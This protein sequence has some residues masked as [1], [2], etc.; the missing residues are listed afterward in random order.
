MALSSPTKKPRGVLVQQQTSCYQ[1]YVLLLLGLGLGSLLVFIYYTD[2]IQHA[3]LPRLKAQVKRTVCSMMT[4]PC[5]SLE[6]EARDQ[7]RERA[8]ERNRDVLFVAT[9]SGRRRKSF[10]VGDADEKMYG[11]DLSARDT[12]R[13]H[14]RDA[15]RKTLNVP[16][17]GRRRRLPILLQGKKRPGVEK[18]SPFRLLRVKIRDKG[19]NFPGS[20]GA[21]NSPKRRP[22][23]SDFAEVA[24]GGHFQMNKQRRSE[25]DDIPDFARN[26]RLKYRTHD[27][28][29]PFKRERELNENE[30]SANEEITSKYKEKN[31]ANNFNLNQNMKKHHPKNYRGKDVL[32]DLRDGKEDPFGNSPKPGAR[33]PHNGPD[34]AQNALSRPHGNKKEDILNSKQNHPP[35]L[36]QNVTFGLKDRRSNIP[37]GET[38]DEAKWL[39]G[40]TLPNENT[41]PKDKTT[42]N[43]STDANNNMSQK[44]PRDIKRIGKSPNAMPNSETADSAQSTI[45]PSENRT[46]TE[47]DNDSPQ[48]KKKSKPREDEM[49]KGESPESRRKLTLRRNTMNSTGLGLDG[50]W[51]GKSLK[52]HLAD[53]TPFS[54]QSDYDYLQQHLLSGGLNLTMMSRQRWP[55]E[56]RSN[57]RNFYLDP[58]LENINQAATHMTSHVT[59]LEP[60]P[61]YSVGDVIKVRVDV[62]DGNGNP[63]KRGGDEVRVWLVERAKG[64]SLA[65][66]VTDLNNGSYIAHLQLQWPGVQQIQAELTFSREALR[67]HD[68]LRHVTKVMRYIAGGFSKGPLSE[69]TLCSPFPEIPGYPDLCNYSHPV[70]GLSWFCGKPRKPELQCEDWVSIRDMEF[71]AP[72]PLTQDFEPSFANAEPCYAVPSVGLMMRNTVSG[73]SHRLKE[74][75]VSGETHGDERCKGGVKSQGYRWQLWG[76]DG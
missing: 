3:V 9:R 73:R 50:K 70:Y 54:I 7:T 20:D 49:K 18:F 48:V 19:V 16:I 40:K 53:R 56:M 36:Q 23:L 4:L 28:Y 13:K 65:G 5:P 12:G 14:T 64:A 10:S 24:E 66:I 42:T 63:L 55:K 37:G 76:K 15:S 32:K 35:Q 46:S 2:H 17:F 69:A 75:G 47:S 60:R 45:A 61:S 71:F 59:L 38:E 72:L 25:S 52:I 57:T 8:T 11:K 39:A 68:Y 62:Y 22:E 27:S 34:V 21:N 44:R 6:E 41:Q 74:V 43:P 33:I 31:Q 26:H 30:R 58:P 67:A 1:R 29:I 51:S